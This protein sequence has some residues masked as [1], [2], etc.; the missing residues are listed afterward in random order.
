[1]RCPA[2]PAISIT[3]MPRSKYSG[4]AFRTLSN[5][6]GYSDASTASPSPV[7]S[8]PAGY[9]FFMKR[10]VA[11]PIAP[12]TT[13]FFQ[14][15]MVPPIAN[16]FPRLYPLAHNLLHL[17][18]MPLSRPLLSSASQVVNARL[19]PFCHSDRSRSVSD[20]GA[21]EPASCYHHSSA[22]YNRPSFIL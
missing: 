22:S 13:A 19:D 18:P 21:E 3:R 12:A 1:M 10:I 11:D 17:C 4:R 6:S 5:F 16:F 8:T 9:L 15:S 7:A 2:R 14:L 20:G